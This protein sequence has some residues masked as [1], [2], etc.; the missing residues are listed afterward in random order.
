VATTVHL[1]QVAVEPT[2]AE[3][4]SSRLGGGT[5]PVQVK[6]EKIIARKDLQGIPKNPFSILHFVD[7][8]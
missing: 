4:R 1:K 7:N 3:R 8:S 6:A 5:T 2:Q